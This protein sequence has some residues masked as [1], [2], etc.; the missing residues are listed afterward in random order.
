MPREMRVVPYDPAWPALFEREK[1]AL[2]GV[3]GPLLVDIQHFGSTAIPGMSAKPI[4]DVMAV[5]A[6]IEGV[7]A[8]NEAMIRAGYTPRGENGMPGRR[9]FVRYREDGENHAAHVHIHGPGNAHTADELLFRDFLCENREAFLQ[10]E[11]VKLDAAEKYRWSP[12]EYTDAETGCVM[13]IM[14]KAREHHAP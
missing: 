1:A 13:E 9:Y 2:E 5:A 11:S 8:Y 14:A 12:L 7:D 6:R 10:Y 3:F 4:I